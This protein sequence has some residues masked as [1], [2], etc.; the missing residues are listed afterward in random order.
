[1]SEEAGLGLRE[2]ARALAAEAVRREFRTAL[3]RAGTRVVELEPAVWLARPG[4]AGDRVGDWVRD[5]ALGRDAFV[6]PRGGVVVV[7]AVPRVPGASARSSAS[8]AAACGA[9]ADEGRDPAGRW[10]RHRARAEARSS[11]PLAG[12]YEARELHAAGR[13]WTGRPAEEVSFSGHGFRVPRGVFAPTGASAQLLAR[14]LAA[15]NAPAPDAPAPD[16]ATPAAAAGQVLADIG[17]GSGV[18]A[19][20]AALAP[21]SLRVVAGDASPRAVRAARANARRAGLHTEERADA[22]ADQAS[23]DESAPLRNGNSGDGHAKACEKAGPRHAPLGPHRHDRLDRA[24]ARP[25]HQERSD[26]RA[27]ARVQAREPEGNHLGPE[28]AAL[29]HQP[30][31]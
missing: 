25:V 17:T 20:S 11:G 30:G 28:D 1:M 22:G 14:V 2:A 21:P 9:D 23:G 12:W 18:I 3:E 8:V 27:G 10:R 4:P 5:D 7:S 29:L 31:G 13:G 26:R 15:L 24:A 6:H 19:V 16:A